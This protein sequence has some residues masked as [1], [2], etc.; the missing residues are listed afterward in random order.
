MSDGPVVVAVLSHRDPALLRRLTSSV[1]TGERSVVLVHHDPRGEPHG[2]TQ[3]ERLRLVPDPQPCAWGRMNFAEAMVQCVRSAVTTFPDL[4]WV[5]L[6]SGQDYP[7]QAMQLTESALAAEDH[8]AL[9]RCFPVTDD[10]AQDVH[11]WQARCRARYLHR[12]R[13]PGTH[14]SVPS[15]RRPPF[16]DGTELYVGDTWPNLDAAAARHLLEQYDRMTVVRRYLARCSNPDEALLPTLLLNDADNLQVG[17]DRKRYIRWPEQAAHPATLVESDARAIL[18]SGDFFA[19]KVDGIV[20]AA[21]LD[22]LDQAHA[23]QR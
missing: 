1:L 11:P 4:S 17:N 21:L 13:L 12:L 23:A 3:S 20:S 9:L 5:L 19:R 7:A 6:V 15:L 10:P 16:R 14:R 8:H 22:E 2:L 18:S